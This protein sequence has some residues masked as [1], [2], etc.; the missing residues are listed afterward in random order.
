MHIT[1]TTHLHVRFD[2]GDDCWFK[3][4]CAEFMR[5][6]ASQDLHDNTNQIDIRFYHYN[7]SIIIIIII[8][9]HI[10]EKRCATQYQRKLS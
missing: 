4:R 2:V 6:A 10:K 7:A 5:F 8:R 1:H 9:M 3:E